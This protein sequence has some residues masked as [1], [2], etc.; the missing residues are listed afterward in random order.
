MKTKQSSPKKFLK[1]FFKPSTQKVFALQTNFS[2]KQIPLHSIQKM[3]TI[4]GYTEIIIRKGSG[5][6]GNQNLDC[7]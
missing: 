5:F 1:G 3:F 6:H 7:G 4:Y 2:K